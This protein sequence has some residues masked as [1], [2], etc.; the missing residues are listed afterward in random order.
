MGKEKKKGVFAINLEA[1]FTAGKCTT[2]K[3][4]CLSLL[5][6]KIFDKTLFP[7]FIVLWRV[8]VIRKSWSLCWFYILSV[9][10]WYL[11]GAYLCLSGMVNPSLFFILSQ[12]IRATILKASLVRCTVSHTHTHKWILVSEHTSTFCYFHM[13]TKMLEKRWLP[14]HATFLQSVSH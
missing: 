4:W 12:R 2:V 8:P 13:Q 3:Q 5:Q 1:S 14:L 6:L 7:W 9:T 10:F 11:H